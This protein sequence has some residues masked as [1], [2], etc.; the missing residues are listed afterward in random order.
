MSANESTDAPD[1]SANALYVGNLDRRVTDVMMMNILKSGL[2]HIEDKI[3][4][5]KMFAN[6]P[7]QGPEGHCFIQF[8]DNS[9]ANQGM[10][11]LNGKDFCGKIVKVNWATNSNNGG[12][13]GYKVLNSSVTIFVG[14][15]DDEIT[16]TEL[17]QAFDPFGEILNAKVVRDPMTQKSKNYGFISFVNKPDAEKAIR[18][19]SGAMLKRRPIKTNWA[20][21]NQKPQQPTNLDFDQVSGESSISNCTVYVTNLPIR[22]TDDEVMKHFADFGKIVSKPRLFEGKNFCFIK[23]D[24]HDAA[25]KAI[26][27]GNGTE[28]GG[29]VLKCWWGKENSGDYHNG[30]SSNYSNNRMQHMNGN[31]QQQKQNAM[32]QQYMQY[33][34]SPV[35]QQQYY[36]YMMQYQQQMMQQAGAQGGASASP[37]QQQQQQTGQYGQPYQGYNNYNQ[38]Q[39]G[40]Q[41]GG[42][43]SQ[44]GYRPNTYQN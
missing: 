13:G 21:R 15:L 44:G 24:S 37:Q 19:M 27:E 33:Y 22:I 10:G 28:L 1:P 41:Q 23:Y 9:S 40:Q 3:L 17:R 7:S 16:D 36:Q 2:S 39:G 6:D 4:S 30:P 29:S 14:D 5:V 31:Q 26:V 20:T 12:A 18:D 34:S 8:T 32:Y 42:A 11:F 35:Y 38:Q 43:H 25:T